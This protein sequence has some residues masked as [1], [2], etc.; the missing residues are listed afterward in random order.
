MT[1]KLNVPPANQAAPSRSQA[2]MFIVMLGVVSLFADMNYEGGRSL[3][4]QYIN[5][6]GASA[7]ALSLAAGLGEF[8]GYGLRFFSGVLVDK[9]K[10]YWFIMFTGYG[11]QL[12]AL[13]ALALTGDWRWAVALLLLER[14]AKAYR[15]PAGDAVLAYASFAPGRGFGFGLH[16]AMDQVGAFLGPALL[17]ALLFFNKDGAGLGGLRLGL[18][19][20]FVPAAGAV[21]AL[22]VA[23]HFFPHPDRFELPDKAPLIGTSGISRGLWIVIIA[24]GFLAAGI[25]DFPLIAFH[26][27]KTGN[28]PAA[29]IPLLYAGSMAVDAAAALLLGKLYDRLGYP[30]L[31]ILFVV[32]IFTAP[33]LFLGGTTAI[34]VGMALWGVSMGTQE[35]VLKAVIADHSAKDYRGR[36]FGLFQ[37]VFGAFWFAG[38]ALLGWLYG[39]GIPALVAASV[40]LQGIALILSIAAGTVLKKEEN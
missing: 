1:K 13:P 39:V 20:L 4:G 22:A 17:S 24:A 26:L 34:V 25:T 27:N 3:S 15:K 6:L 21:L 5:L 35:S 19:L 28:F 40:A 23:R 33:L 31:L 10:S 7:F 38:S 9:T 16:E 8:L 37:T 30:A 2:V 11:I 29:A 12:C 36:A 14:I 18:L 32:E